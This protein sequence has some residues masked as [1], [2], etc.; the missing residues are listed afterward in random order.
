MGYEKNELQKQ[1]LEQISEMLSDAL[2]LL[3]LLENDIE[4]QKLDGIY[5]R[6]LKMMH[7][8]LKGIQKELSAYMRQEGE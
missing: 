7:G 8:N 1:D 5:M 3:I 4:M 6:I 2:S